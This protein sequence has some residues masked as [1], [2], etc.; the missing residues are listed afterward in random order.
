[1][2]PKYLWFTNLPFLTGDIRPED[3]KSF[4][5]FDRVKTMAV[6]NDR[7]NISLVPCFSQRAGKVV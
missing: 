6:L 4:D 2:S 7:K 3:K 1:V 5:R